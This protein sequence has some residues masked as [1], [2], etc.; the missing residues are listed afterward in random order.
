MK[1][2]SKACR[3][4]SIELAQLLAL[5]P[6]LQGFHDNFQEQGYACAGATLR[7]ARNRTW[8]ARLVMRNRDE[9]VSTVTFTTRGLVIA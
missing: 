8:T 3:T 6:M 7:R 2:A 5:D 9:A 4:P 1:R